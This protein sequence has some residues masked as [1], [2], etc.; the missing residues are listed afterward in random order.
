[1]RRHYTLQEYKDLIAKLRSRIKDLSITTDII[2]GF[3]QETD[4]DFEETFEYSTWKLVLPHIH[5]FPY[6]IR[7][8]TPAATMPDQVPEAVKK[9][10][11]ALLNGLSQAGYEAYAKSRIGKPGEILIEKEENGYYMGLT[12]EYVMVK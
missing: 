4:E 11:V 10:R 5:A 2:A 8:G 12:N 1:M 6:S 9:T 7:E 3:P